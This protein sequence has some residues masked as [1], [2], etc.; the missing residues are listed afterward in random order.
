MKCFLKKAEM[1]QIATQLKKNATQQQSIRP[2]DCRDTI[3]VWMRVNHRQWLHGSGT[4]SA[5]ATRGGRAHNQSEVI[6]A[7]K[8]KNTHSHIGTTNQHGKKK[9]KR[10]MMMIGQSAN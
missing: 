5:T 7:K 2:S 10:M 3:A 8:Y 6:A 9:K 1:P 4:G